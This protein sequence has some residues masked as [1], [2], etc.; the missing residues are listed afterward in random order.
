MLL[1]ALL[2]LLLCMNLGVAAWWLG[3]RDPPAP[4]PTATEP[5]IPSL[6]LLSEVERRPA[7]E[8][9]AELAE[10][11]APLSANARCL[12][13][14][15]F[16]TPAALRAAMDRLLPKVER[17]QFR[18][19]AAEALRGYR[20]Y[21]PPAGSREEA[22]QVARALS[23]RGVSDY[24]VITAGPQADTVS[25]GLFRDLAT[26]TQRRDEVAALGYS[27]VVEPRTEP[28]SQWWI[29]LAAGPE[30]DWRTVVADAGLRAQPAACR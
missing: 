8:A 11:P 13:L 26:A 27:P 22:L 9:A 17:I 5:G 18:E 29:D 12:S 3:H 20:V 15:P 6:R 4:A 23:D 19:E 7:D 30:F 28:V 16:E 21:L 14:G 2:L 24:Y 25:L 1:R 10:A